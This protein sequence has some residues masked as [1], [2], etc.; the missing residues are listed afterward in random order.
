M[1]TFSFFCLDRT[2]I[3]LRENVFLRKSLDKLDRTEYPT[4]YTYI[5]KNQIYISLRT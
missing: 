4:I 1:K 2:E 5:H 3:F